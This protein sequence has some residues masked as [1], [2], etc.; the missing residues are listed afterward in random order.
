MTLL[1][2]IS[3]ICKVLIM[4]KLLAAVMLKTMETIIC[5]V[6]LLKTSFIRVF[7]EKIIRIISE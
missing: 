7:A 1:S 6:V 4:V 2:Y 5:G 3:K